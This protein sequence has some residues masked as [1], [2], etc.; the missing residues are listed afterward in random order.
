MSRPH[1]L[2]AL[3]L[4]PLAS[5]MAAEAKQ[6]KPAYVYL[7]GD[8]GAGQPTE[9]RAGVGERLVV[10][11]KEQRAEVEVTVRRL[12]ADKQAL[13]YVR[14][15][16]QQRGATGTVPM[17]LP[18]GQWFRLVNVNSG[19][20]LAVKDQAMQEGAKLVQQGTDT[21]DHGLLWRLTRVDEGWYALQNR[22]T[23]QVAA[24][25]DGRK[26]AG[27]NLVQ[28][29]LDKGSADQQWR[30]LWI[31]GDRFVVVNRRSGQALAVAYGAKHPGATICQWPMHIDWGQH[32]WR[33]Q[34]VDVE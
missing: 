2:F 18:V 8:E 31:A 6:P 33:I 29:P 32:Q 27:A 30:P 9:M 14:I 13:I 10:I 1:S 7:S 25:P 22:D 5:A 26:D 21:D 20:G 17:R 3:V 34:V 28:V 4:L 24:L 11:D 16:S 12:P 15:R 23:Q 19:H